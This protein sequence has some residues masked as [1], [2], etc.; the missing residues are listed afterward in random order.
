MGKDLYDIGLITEDVKVINR[1]REISEEFEFS[2]VHWK[3]LEDLSE[4]GLSCK[5]YVY[6]NINESDQAL[7][8]KELAQKLTEATQTI[9]FE[10]GE[11]CFVIALTKKMLPK[12]DVAFLRK[13]GLNYVIQVDEVFETSKLEFL[14]TQIIRAQYVAIKDVDLIPGQPLL[15]DLYHLMPLKEKFLKIA[16]KGAILTEEKILNKFSKISE[17]YVQREE[18]SN[19]KEYAS[20]GGNGSQQDQLRQCRAQFLE[21]F[22]VYTDLVARLTD[23][24]ETLSF[25]E[26]K[27]L[28]EKCD[29]LV[30]ELAE[31]LVK[32]GVDDVWGVVNNSAI[33][34]FGSLERTT[35]VA[36]YAAFFSMRMKYEN[37][38]HL[39]FSSLMAQLGI[40]FLSPK[41]TQK[42][43]QNQIEELNE[44]E[45]ATYHKYPIKSLDLILSR[46][47]PLDQE[48]K[49]II[50]L[51][52]ERADGSGFPLN[53]KGAKL[54]N[55]SQLLGFC[56]DFDQR[57][58][59]R[60]GERRKTQ[61]DILKDK[62]RE[63]MA[64]GKSFKMSFLGDLKKAFAA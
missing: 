14:A 37:R 40:I 3:N 7:S 59:I 28:F 6:S 44:E 51:C 9:K 41:I 33:G 61:V 39:I 52:N 11:D 55:Q 12:E 25:E 21:F 49:D 22:G 4:N 32:L 34:D 5:L 35:A 16:S 17:F 64:S 24:S 58:L 43:R 18:L 60:M 50:M 10:G 23:H 19:L 20:R 26:G 29:Q 57:T 15:F 2:Q 38:N 46:R 47:L 63:E 31:S 1:F 53:V 54:T 8:S 62:I 13:S 48:V 42:L 56:L 30:N 45:L 27:K 36:A